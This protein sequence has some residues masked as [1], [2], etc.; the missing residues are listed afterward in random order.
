M[1]L[2]TAIYTLNFFLLSYGTPLHLHGLTHA[3]PTRRS[4]D[5][6]ASKPNRAEQRSLAIRYDNRTRAG[7]IC[8]CLLTGSSLWPQRRSVQSGTA[9][10]IHDQQGSAASA[11][12]Q[13]APHQANDR[14]NG[15]CSPAQAGAGNDTPGPFGRAFGGGDGLSSRLCPCLPSCWAP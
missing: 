13:P 14:R 11:R 6:S 3:F 4:S 12:H 1:T 5:L 8:L 2:Y 10:H 7:R 9:L 15:L